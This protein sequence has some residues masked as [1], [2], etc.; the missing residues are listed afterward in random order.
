MSKIIFN[1]MQMKQL[2][3]NENL[4]KVSERSSCKC[5]KK[6]KTTVYG[7]KIVLL[8]RVIFYFPLRIA[9]HYIKK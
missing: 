9:L 3:K 5:F 1:E 7:I 4:V 8:S 6:H 2:E